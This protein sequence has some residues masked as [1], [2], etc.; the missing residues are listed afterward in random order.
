[1]EETIDLKFVYV[2][3]ST[4]YNT[5]TSELIDMWQGKMQQKIY[6]RK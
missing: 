6:E 1:M 4:A 2:I 3:Y 5:E